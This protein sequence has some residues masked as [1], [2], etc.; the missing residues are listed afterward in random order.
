MTRAS[1]SAALNSTSSSIS[2]NTIAIFEDVRVNF[3]KQV[4]F[5][6]S[7]TSNSSSAAFIRSAAAYSTSTTPDYTWWYNDQTG[8][9]HPAANRIGMSIGGNQKFILNSVGLLLA[10][11]NVT[12]PSSRLHLDG[13][14]SVA[15]FLQFTSG[16]LT[17]TGTNTGFLIGINGSGYP[18]LSSRYTNSPYLLTFTNGN[19]FYKIGRN[20]FT[21]YSNPNGENF[22]TVTTN[23]G[24][25]TIEGTNIGFSSGPGT[26]L[27]SSISVPNSCLVSIEATFVASLIGP[28]KQFRTNKI[29]AQYSVNSS[30]TITPQ[31]FLGTTSGISLAMLQS[32]NGAVG[33][34]A[35]TFNI[36]TSNTIRLS[37][38]FNAPAQ[39]GWSTVSFKAVI[40]ASTGH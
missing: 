21:M 14:N 23:A 28:T 7:G 26:I 40:N 10:D 12:T 32:S 17:G 2:S 22:A 37:Q 27:I 25:R 34:A 16:S 1:N 33:I 38:T 5:N 36:L 39:S 20:E 13:G 6:S 8:I 35:G 19:T 9:Y 11:S 4:H 18:V 29:I 30:G 24:Y 15:S 3:L 31:N